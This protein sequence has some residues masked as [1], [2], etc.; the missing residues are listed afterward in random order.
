MT[1]VRE[2]RVDPD[3][4]ATHR[5]L[6]NTPQIVVGGP[7][8]G[9]TQFLCDRV[10]HAVDTGQ[11]TTD[12]VIFL[13]FSR[14][15]VNDIRTRLF[16]ALGSRSYRVNVSTYH[17][18]AMRIVEAHATDLG[19]PSPP[20]IL[21]GAEQEHFVAALL[22]DEDPKQWHASFRGILTTEAIAGEVTDFILRCHEHLL[23]PQDVAAH[24]RDQWRALPEFFEKYLLRQVASG[25]TDYGRILAD[26]VRVVE[27]LP[28]VTAP[29]KLIVADEYQDT[30][31]AQARLLLGLANSTTDLLVAADP[32]QSIYS[33]R[34]TDLHNVFRFPEATEVALGSRA[35]RLILTTSFRVPVEILSSAVALTARE[36]PGGAGRV[37]STRS[38]GSVSAHI[39]TLDAEEADWIAED[40]EHT[41]LRHGVPLERIAVFVRSTAPFTH[42]LSR[43]LSR[44]DLP[45]TSEESRLTDQPIIRFV[46]DLVTASTSEENGDEALRRALL[47]PYIGVPHGALVSMG[48]RRARG[49]AWAA[50]VEEGVA[51]A[52]A[53]AAL[54]SDPSWANRHPASSG[55]W[56]VWSTLPHLT[57]IATEDAL[58]NDRQA[59]SAFAQALDRLA[60][61]SP[62]ATLADHEQLV[63]HSDYEADP[64]FDFRL[65]DHRGITITTLH[66]SKGTDFDVL[67]IA[68]ATEGTLPDL[69]ATDSILGSRHL[70]PHLPA[71]TASYRV[72]RLDEERRLA[73]TAMTRASRKVVWTATCEAGPR[74]RSPSRFLPLVAP[75]TDA[76]H[77]GDPLTHRSFEADLRRTLNSPQ[78]LDSERLAAAMTLSRGPNIGLGAPLERYGAPLPGSDDHLLQGALRMSPSQ[79]TGYLDCPRKYAIERFLMTRSEGTEYMRFGSL[80]HSVLEDVERDAAESGRVHGSAEDA[81]AQLDLVWDDFDFGDDA[82]GR[83]WYNKAVKMLTDT[84][85][86]W[87]T[88][89]KAVG[90]ETGLEMTIDG[91]SW[92][93]FADRIEKRGAGVFVIDYK[94]GRQFSI[95]EAAESIQLG[96]YA[97]VAAENS[98]ITQHGSV[99]GAEFWFTNIANKSSIGTRAFDMANLDLVRDTMV[100]V[101]RAIKAEHFDPTPG[102]HC[103]SCDVELVCPA[104]AAGAEAFA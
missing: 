83:A 92:L 70:N 30:S 44:R 77:H 100:S 58:V 35:E 28:E 39:F 17:S 99:V 67:Y 63:S 74:G 59:W 12:E 34:G 68:Q 69:R 55:L 97:M 93:G 57:R 25:R 51:Q 78:H 7:G 43:A 84:Y 98:D 11:V 61:R 87:P 81:T 14:Q 65:D 64:L 19:W 24:K 10:S 48:E 31:P 79:A 102:P 52:S 62:K 53:L 1:E 73:Y 66:R 76:E 75:I 46:R 45:H 56:H 27:D 26:A 6:A 60:E 5:M 20:T 50:I 85:N 8:T 101:S 29:Y 13:T 33:F 54:L 42:E 38:G 36:L 15:G 2:V 23:T 9:K 96:Y 86:L 80:I 47:S 82:V 41:H 22:K 40:I 94:T 72:F 49:E 88:S 91:T 4:W 37:L 21:A 103:A 95:P 32:Y 16:E 18:L 71:D 104:R 89:A 90:F 3:D